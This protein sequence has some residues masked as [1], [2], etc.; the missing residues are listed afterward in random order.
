MAQLVGVVGEE[1]S[2]Q[3]RLGLLERCVRLLGAQLVDLPLKRQHRGLQLLDVNPDLAIID[4]AII[5]GCGGVWL[6]RKT[7]R[8]PAGRPTR[9]AQRRCDRVLDAVDSGIAGR[10]VGA[11]DC[12]PAVGADDP[13]CPAVCGQVLA[14]IQKT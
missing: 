5:A 2:G 6:V 13:H 9:G 12:T 1:P 7:E 10:F 11:D 14:A 4:L 8:W 3:G